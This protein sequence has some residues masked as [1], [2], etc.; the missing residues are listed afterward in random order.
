M[1]LCKYYGA[2]M[3][4]YT[5]NLKGAIHVLLEK[6]ADDHTWAIPGGALDDLEDYASFHRREN[7]AKRTTSLAATLNIG[8]EYVFPF[9]DKLRFGFLSS[10]RINGQYSWSEGRLS[11]NVAPLKW[12]D[13]GVNYGLSSFGSSFGWLLNFHPRGFNFFIGMDHL[14]GKV[15]P[16]FIPVGSANMNVSFGFNVTFGG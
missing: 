7:G 6:R 10:T 15:S 3:I 5:K 14:M 11:A 9:Y 2:G 4:L 12:F 13:A 8:A 1:G 16:Q